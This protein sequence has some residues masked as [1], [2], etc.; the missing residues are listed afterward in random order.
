MQSIF[1]INNHI[2]YNNGGIVGVRMRK[3]KTGISIY[4]E[5]AESFDFYRLER[6]ETIKYQWPASKSIL[7]DM[8]I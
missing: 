1:K 3:I 7:Y 2:V 6:I 5:M 4:F 8:A